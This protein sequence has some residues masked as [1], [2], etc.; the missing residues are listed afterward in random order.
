MVRC[1]ENP[2]IKDSMPST[3]HFTWNGLD[4]QMLSR[5]D[6]VTPRGSFRWYGQQTNMG[7]SR[8]IY[9]WLIHRT[10]A[11]L[12]Q[13]LSCH[14]MSGVRQPRQ[15]AFCTLGRCDR[16]DEP[17]CTFQHQMR[18]RPQ[19]RRHL[20]KTHMRWCRIRLPF[21]RSPAAR[22]KPRVSAETQTGSPRSKSEIECARYRGKI[23]RIRQPDRG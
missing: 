5:S 22:R 17:M 3:V 1:L 16:V 18:S 13:F 7:T 21:P 2:R 23:I 20:R 11:I 4:G 9:H 19:M 14:A 8:S 10:E 15:D 6:G 12:A